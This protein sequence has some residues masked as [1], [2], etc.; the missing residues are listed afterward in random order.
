MKLTLPAITSVRAGALPRNGTWVIFVPDSVSSS[1]PA[2]WADPPLPADAYDT[3]SGFAFAAFTTS[4]TEL[5]GESGLVTMTSGR[6]ATRLTGA[7]S[8]I[9]S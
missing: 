2:R 1:A 9:G 8:A 5:N 7:K 6:N 3:S 4:G